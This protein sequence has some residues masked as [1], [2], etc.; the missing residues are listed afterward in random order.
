MGIQIKNETAQFLIRLAD[1]EIILGQRLA[2][3]CSKAPFLEEDIALSNLSLD[4]FGR[5]EELLKLVSELEGGQHSPDDYTFHRNEREYFNLK[6]VEQ[7]HQD[8]AGVIVRQFLHDVYVHEVFEQLLQSDI[9]GVSGLAEKV[10]KE[11]KYSYLHSK[12]W[13]IRLGN[14]TQES[15]QR[16]QSALNRMW[17]YTQEIF[18]FD[19]IDQTYLT[20]VNA[21]EN[22]WKTEVNN[23]CTEAQLEVP[24]LEK[25]HYLNYRQGVHSEYLG[26]LLALMQY[27]PRAYPDAK[28]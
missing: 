11:I 23:I 1:T 17:K 7:P 20:D 9:N 18:E 21:I 15:Q 14:G 13:M 10:L 6:L 8:F 16:L 3:M 2:E 12:E 26:E 24:I 5:G 19:H 4:L 27:I 22:S 28:W 25:Q